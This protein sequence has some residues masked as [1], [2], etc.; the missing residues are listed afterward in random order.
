MKTCLS[1]ICLTLL[2][3]GSAILTATDA[4]PGVIDIGSRRELFVDDSLIDQ[5]VG[6][7]ELRLHHPVEREVAIK[8]DAPWEGS[9]SSYATVFRD[10]DLY[11]MYY[12]GLQYT[13][14]DGKLGAPHPPVTCYA[15]SR[16]G[17]VWEKPNLGLFEWGGSK[18]NNIVWDGRRAVDNFTPFKDTR[19][20]VPEDQRYKAVAYANQ[21]GRAMAAYVSPD[22]LRWR[23][24]TDKPV[25]TVGPDTFDS[26]NVAFWDET[27]GEYRAY[28]RDKHRGYRDV[29][30]A[31]SPDFLNWS[32]AEWLEYPDSPRTQLY[33]NQIKPYYR[34]KH[35]FIGLPAR[36]AQYKNLEAVKHL[37][38]AEHWEERAA[39]RLRYGTAITDTLLISSR[40]GRTFHRWNEA[41]IR[42]GPERPGTWNYGH[43]FTAW[44][45]L[46]TQSGIDGAP[47][48]LS[49]YANESKWT[50]T[51]AFVR[52]YTLRIDGFAS[53]H[54]GGAGGEVH[55]KPLSFD[56]KE[57]LLN[58]A[59]SARGHIL[60]AIH[61]EDDRL[62][63]GFGIDDAVPIFGDSIDRKARWKGDPD[64]TKLAGKPVRL[65]FVLREADLFSIQ[66][67]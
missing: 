13:V 38:D 52:R 19:P 6:Q 42:P 1:A 26:Q 65:R 59:T 29:R 53:V 41:F 34:A 36:Y 3:L 49:I 12:R 33:T 44:G 37:P 43:L 62:I 60:V 55:T 8:L 30:T 20:G 31:T 21:R 39:D 47:N 48:E 5:F 25:L 51:E 24:L 11:R 61:D 18:E 56:G 32:E 15:E 17:I 27:R 54:S 67:R 28:F 14:T 64:L 58:F 16:D 22:G 35:L 4:A 9:G 7:A 57:L 40:D 63:E 2:L 45:M 46:E 10:G 23:L 66:F 50:G